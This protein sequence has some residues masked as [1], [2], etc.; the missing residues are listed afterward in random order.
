MLLRRHLRLLLLLT[1]LLLLLAELL[2][3][4]VQHFGVCQ[5]L[6]LLMLNDR[7]R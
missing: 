2:L 1:A 3:Q 6:L 5:R 4:P 7:C